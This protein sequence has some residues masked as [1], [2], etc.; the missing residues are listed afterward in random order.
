[1]KTE[2]SVVN[3][4]VAF[5]SKCLWCKMKISNFQTA[6]HIGCSYCYS[7]MLSKVLLPQHMYEN[8]KQTKKKYG[9]HLSNSVVKATT[10]DQKHEL[11]KQGTTYLVNK[12]LGAR[13]QT[14]ANNGKTKVLHFGLT[15]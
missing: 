6:N 3:V 13:Q 1:M 2:T 11:T 14:L 10:T 12:E 7:K 4:M 8:M 5:F 15:L 9:M